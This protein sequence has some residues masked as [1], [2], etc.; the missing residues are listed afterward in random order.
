M[1]GLVGVCQARVETLSG[2]TAD[3]VVDLGFGVQ[4]RARLHLTPPGGGGWRRVRAWVEGRDVVLVQLAGE[5]WRGRTRA[6]LVDGDAPPH[7]YHAE[8]VRVVDGDTLDV[9]VLLGFGVSVRQRLRLLGVNAPERG[10]ADGA[11]AAEFVTRWAADWP[12]LVVRTVKDRSEKYGRILATVWGDPGGLSL[13]ELLLA[14]ELAAPYPG[15]GGGRG[16]VNGATCY[17]T[18]V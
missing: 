9:R 12:R 3:A 4:V 10:T 17:H 18:R 2:C 5:P 6:L 11:R 1:V 16:D 15:V 14:N 13:N 7:V 8:Q